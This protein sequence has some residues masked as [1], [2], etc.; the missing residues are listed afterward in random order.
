[1]SNLIPKLEFIAQSLFLKQDK[2]PHCNSLNLK[3]IAK[4][5]SVITIKECQDCNL[6]FTS[7]IYKPLLISNLY[8]SFY[9]AEGS[10]TIVP[11]DDELAKLKEN[12]FLTSDKYFGDRIKA[13]KSCEIGQKLLEVGS[14]WGYFL[15]QAKQ[16]GFDVTGVEISQPRR[17]FGVEKL[18][19]D[20]VSSFG[21]LNEK[22]FDIIYTSHVLEHFQDISTVFREMYDLLRIG[23]RLFIEVP[24]FDYSVFG[25]EV[26]SI[27]GAVHPLGYS[28]E[29]FSQNLAEYGFKLMGFYDSWECFPNYPVPKSQKEVIILMA[30]KG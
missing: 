18:G 28:S 8:D 20:I 9:S 23:G 11:N 7:P 3:Q 27:I 22:E 30:E 16:Q 15:Y 10:T 26:L 21:E 4:K 14:S 1:M 25:Q 24:N 12:C 13:I 17:L 29:F 19:V 6:Y 5:Y 2:C